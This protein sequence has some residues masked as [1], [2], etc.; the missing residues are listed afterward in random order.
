LIAAYVKSSAAQPRKPDTATV[1]LATA[2]AVDFT[3]DI[4]PVL[5]RSCVGCHGGKKP[6]GG[7]AMLSRELLLKGG[8]SGEPAVTPG[9]GAQSAMIQYASGK[10]EDL[11]MPPLDRREKY[12]PLSATE[13]EQLR[14]WIDAGAPWPGEKK[15]E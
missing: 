6:R 9:H 7:L 4:Q 12:P 1:D 11:E 13:L 14:V 3:R 15:T 5:E 2:A 10:I 8:A